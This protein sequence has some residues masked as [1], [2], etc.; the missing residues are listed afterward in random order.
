MTWSNQ[1]DRPSG[2]QKWKRTAKAL[3]RKYRTLLATEKTRADTLSEAMKVLF[4]EMAD[5]V[6][7]TK[8]VIEDGDEEEAP[9]VS[10][11]R[12]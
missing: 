9:Y 7:R 4:A 5:A 8:V 11:D 10:K 12:N 2:A 3:R 1:D 6:G